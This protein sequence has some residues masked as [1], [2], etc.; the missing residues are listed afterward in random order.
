[1]AELELHMHARTSGSI[2]VFT[3][4]F[5]FFPFLFFCFRWCPARETYEKHSK[6]QGSAVVIVSRRRLRRQNQIVCHLISSNVGA[7][8]A[9]AS[10]CSSCSFFFAC[11]SSKLAPEKTPS[12][13]LGARSE[14][15]PICQ[16]THSRSP[17]PSGANPSALSLL[18]A[19]RDDALIS[20]PT[21][22]CG[23]WFSSLAAPSN[24]LAISRTLT[25]LQKLILSYFNL[26]L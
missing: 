16:A 8:E 13:N 22:M 17:R 21:S 20:H 11:T 2:S 3:S 14:F 1:M 15:Q 23:T 10:K 19:A 7:E 4:F 24:L 9:Q 26:R 6:T 25:K 5:A 18:T 12:S